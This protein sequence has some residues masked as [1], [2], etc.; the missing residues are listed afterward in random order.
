MKEL[1]TN[2]KGTL[3]KNA[4]SILTGLGVIGFI[5]TVSAAIHDTP[6]AIRILEEA[7]L[8]EPTPLEMAKLTYKCYI[9]TFILGSV[10]IGCII[11]ANSLHTKRNMALASAYSLAELSLGEWRKKVVEQFGENK[12]KAVSD[13]IAGDKMRST[14][15]VDSEIILTGKGETLCYDALSGRY[16]KSD[17][18]T[19]KRA[20]NNLCRDMLSDMFI[21]LNDLYYA[22]DLE[23]TKMGDLVGWHVDDGLME[24]RFSSHLTP[25]GTPCLVLEF[26][27]EPRY[28]YQD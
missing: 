24:P 2:V 5:S 9:R 10:S 13:S 8:E 18:E 27:V 1:V 12:A 11:G 17:I 6:K 25:N 26:D 16:F 7:N 21:T 20:I 28:I 3:T 22:L 19:I 15:V 23:G 4:P 14:P